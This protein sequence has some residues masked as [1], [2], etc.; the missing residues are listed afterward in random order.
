[1]KYSIIGAIRETRCHRAE[2]IATEGNEYDANKTVQGRSHCKEKG[3]QIY[4]FPACYKPSLQFLLHVKQ[5]Q[6][7]KL[8]P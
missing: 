1:M 3:L 7:L 4:T 6:Q 5:F 8:V 2:E